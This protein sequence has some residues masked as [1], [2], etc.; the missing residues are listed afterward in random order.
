MTPE[1]LRNINTKYQAILL[2]SEQE[3]TIQFAAWALLDLY[4]ITNA[5]ENCEE[6]NY[7]KGSVFALRN[8]YEHLVNRCI[9]DLQGRSHLKE[10]SW[11]DEA[12]E[13]MKTLIEGE[14]WNATT[15]PYMMAMCYN[16]FKS[17]LWASEVADVDGKKHIRDS[18]AMSE[19]LKE[20]TN[21]LAY[22]QI[23]PKDLDKI[24][25]DTMSLCHSK[26]GKLA[27]EHPAA[28]Y[29]NLGWSFG[30]Y[31]WQS[32]S[33]L[34]SYKSETSTKEESVEKNSIMLIPPSMN[35]IRYDNISREFIRPNDIW[36][37][38]IVIKLLKLIKW[39]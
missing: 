3:K 30:H 2:L 1:S 9:A 29:V 35:A 24:L 19:H 5:A 22:K 6:L 37:D 16:N 27:S 36:G 7:N 20:L 28:I 10:A 32:P 38:K 8:I 21:V 23:D 11:V 33:L 17:L 34:S 13:K 12:S 26:F 14:T 31:V 25:S 39:S 4:I 18:F 15:Y